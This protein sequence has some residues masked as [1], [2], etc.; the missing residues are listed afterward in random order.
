MIGGQDIYEAEGNIMGEMAVSYRLMASIIPRQ[1]R[2][3]LK[4][5]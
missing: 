2:V 3:D 5:Q 4:A 1:G